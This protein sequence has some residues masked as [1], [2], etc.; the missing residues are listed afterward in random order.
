MFVWQPSSAYQISA[1]LPQPGLWIIDHSDHG[2][3]L[4]KA[5]SE[6]VIDRW[7]SDG[8]AWDGA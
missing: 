8:P 6:L 1:L 4:S 2:L 3:G 7:V 5:V